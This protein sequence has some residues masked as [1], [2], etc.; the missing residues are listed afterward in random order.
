MCRGSFRRMWY[1]IL[2]T[3]VE[4][5]S[6]L[7]RLQDIRRT[8][9]EIEDL[10]ALPRSRVVEEW[11]PVTAPGGGHHNLDSAERMAEKLDPRYATA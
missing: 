2:A 5:A 11:M 8:I 1:D 4:A 10:L 7:T 6:T 9:A 3:P